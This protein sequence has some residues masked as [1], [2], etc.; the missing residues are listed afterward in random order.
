MM[1]FF[2]AQTGAPA[3]LVAVTDPGSVS[4]YANRDLVVLGSAIDQPLV[5]RWQSSMPIQVT[6]TGG[7]LGLPTSWLESLQPGSPIKSLDRQLAAGLLSQDT[8]IDGYVEGFESPLNP[9]RSVVM[10][11][12][13][14][15]NNTGVLS[16]LFAPSLRRGNVYGT[17]SVA[18]N[19]TF[20]SFH[21]AQN[22][23]RA[24]RLSLFDY[25]MLAFTRYYWFLPV[26][27]LISALI[28]GTLLDRVVERRAWQRL[29]PETP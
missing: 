5:N 16:T 8:V 20:Q 6:E 22:T 18:Q 25:M 4:H 26:F 9:E 28:I 7:R 14:D 11:I 17:V 1:G 24:G 29:N 23:Y 3:L 2:G 12:P 27:M 13:R 10:L 19:G 15:S 21:I